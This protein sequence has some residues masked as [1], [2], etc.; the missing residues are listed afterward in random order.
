ME[1]I[2]TPTLRYTSSAQFVSTA[3]RK[4]VAQF[5]GIMRSLLMA[6]SPVLE[7]AN[8]HVL[9]R[10][11]YYVPYFAPLHPG[12]T[13]TTF[14]AISTLVEIL[15]A[16]GVSL[17]ANPNVKK[18]STQDLGH[19][20]MKTALILQILVIII[21]VGIAGLFHHRC[22]KANIKSSK[23]QQPL[24][25]LYISTALI[26]IRTIYRT[27]EHFGMSRAPAN[28]GT[29]WDPMSLSPIVRYEWFFW[30]FEAGLMLSNSF[31]WNGSHPRLYLP[32]DYHVY[33]AQDGKT[34][35][36]GPGWESEQSWI[37]TFIDP[38]GLTAMLAGNNNK[39]KKQRPFWETNGFENVPLV[40]RD[41]GENV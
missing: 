34:E 9:G 26:L 2:T 6:C 1:R 33:L 32:Q 30:T 12:R 3:L 14:G 11:L 38:C 29:D 13:L 17:L 15:N 40:K 36:Q 39:G 41:N 20:L 5:W 7:L 25:T 24:L 35:L 18:Q 19:I 37:M 23:V 27:I 10:I 31:L 22:R 4:F 21:F 8:Y 28:P 16:L